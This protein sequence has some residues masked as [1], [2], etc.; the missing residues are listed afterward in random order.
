M[1]RST[2]NA[3]AFA[4]ALGA[5]TVGAGAT[6]PASVDKADGRILAIQQSSYDETTLRSFAVA[7]AEVQEI[8]ADWRPQIEAAAPEQAEELRQ[9][10]NAEMV[11]AVERNA[12]TVEA[13]NNI[14]QAAEADSELRARIEAMMADGQ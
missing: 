12:L 9:Q 8:A 11:E 7:L 2:I 3:V 13:Y 10:A 6:P 4:A 14:W 1:I 5:F